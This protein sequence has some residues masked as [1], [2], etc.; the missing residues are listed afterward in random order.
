MSNICILTDSTVQF[1]QPNFPGHD[2]VH[3]IPF[4]YETKKRGGNY[5]QPGEGNFHLTSPSK[6]EFIRFYNRL[7]QDYERI[8]VL[9]LSSRLNPANQIAHSAALD[10]RT[11]ATVDVIDSKS[12][13]IGLG[14]LVQEAALAALAGASLAEMER[15]VR[16]SI[17]RIYMLLCIPE[18]TYLAQSGYMEY[19]QAVVGEMMGILPIF[20]IEDGRLLA[21]EK[22]RTQRHLF[23]FFLEFMDEFEFPDHIA[24]ARGTSHKAMR[25]RPF[26][27]YVEETYPDTPFSEHTISPHLAMMFGPQS[28]GL[29][30][31]DR[32]D[33]RIL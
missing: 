24:L 6:Q 2:R 10:H 3:I 19:S 33:M 30:I 32:T 14:L 23:E 7:S 22:V 5:F 4:T 1:T 16:A 26:H 12:I 13:G 9:T 21:M 31:L 25:T 28:T 11:P 8:F 18:L 20:T 27:Q 15:R 17:P 29:V